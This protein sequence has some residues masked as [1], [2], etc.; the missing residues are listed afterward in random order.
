MKIVFYE[1]PQK[2]STHVT[3][4]SLCQS[5]IFWDPRGIEGTVFQ[6]AFLAGGITDVS[7]WFQTF[8]ALGTLQLG[9]PVTL[10]ISNWKVRN[11]ALLPTRSD[12]FCTYF[13]RTV[14]AVLPQ[15]L[16]ELSAYFQ[17]SVGIIP[18]HLPNRPSF[19]IFICSLFVFTSF[20]AVYTPAVLTASFLKNEAV[21]Y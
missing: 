12:M 19:Q 5:G 8:P 1:Q 18:W 6:E 16:R 17:E 21:T 14:R 7:L 11:V 2:P 20:I 3:S 4:L 9:V 15:V 10:K 13:I